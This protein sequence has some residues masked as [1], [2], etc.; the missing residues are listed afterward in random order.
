M[1]VHYSFIGTMQNITVTLRCSMKKV[2]LKIFAKFTGKHLWKSLFFNKV[3]GHLRNF[4][5][6]FFYR[7]LPVA[8]S[9]AWKYKKVISLK[10]SYSHTSSRSMMQRLRFRLY[11]TD[12]LMPC[13]WTIYLHVKALR[14]YQK[15]LCKSS[16]LEIGKQII[17]ITFSSFAFLILL[18]LDLMPEH[19]AFSPDTYGEYQ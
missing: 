3:A 14:V 10:T 18:Y 17:S 7:T 5:N 12:I 11:S 2:L 9:L 19:C 15:H 6:H 13:F 8:F 1:C 4:Y 16:D